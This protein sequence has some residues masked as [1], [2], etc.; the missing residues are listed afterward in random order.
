MT[1]ALRARSA[2]VLAAVTLGF[3]VAA[4]GSDDEG[5]SGGHMGSTMPTMPEL[6]ATPTASASIAAGSP[7]A[8]PH[9]QADVD[10]AAGMIPHHGQAIQMADMVLAT[11]SNAQ[12]RALAERIKAA[13]NPEIATMSGWLRGWQADVPDPFAADAMGGMH[14]DHLMSADDMAEM[15]SA[16]GAAADRMFLTMMPEHHEGAIA[17]ARDELSAGTNPS[18]KALAEKIIDDQTAEITEMTSM[19]ARMG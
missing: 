8:G 16:S 19:L 3:A 11:T 10:F 12:V 13:Q 6:S 1:R 17:M 5:G 18:A 7:A 4:C 15:R 2:L 9:S 14:G